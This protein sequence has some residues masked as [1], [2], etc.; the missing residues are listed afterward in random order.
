MTNSNNS[1]LV[2]NVENFKTIN[3]FETMEAFDCWMTGNTRFGLVTL[4]ADSDGEY[5]YV[6]LVAA[7]SGPDYMMDMATG[8]MEAVEKVDPAVE[9]ELKM[10]IMM[11]INDDLDDDITIAPIAFT[12]PVSQPLAQKSSPSPYKGCLL[13]TSDAADE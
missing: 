11:E 1:I 4:D 5:A 10:D 12:A 13:Y 7:A 3:T 8:E 9:F 6:A 2:Q